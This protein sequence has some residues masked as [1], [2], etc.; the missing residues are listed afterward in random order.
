M[1][2]L[3]KTKKALMIA[4]KAF[5]NALPFFAAVFVLIGLIDVFV[6]Q[7][8]IIALMG[9]SRGIL[10]PAFA[11]FAGGILAGP[12]AAA[13]PMARV[14]LQRGAAVSAVATFIIAW[15]AVGTVSLPVEIKLLGARF[16][17][18]RWALTIVLSVILGMVI[19]WLV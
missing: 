12:P 19:G 10:A 13:Y 4:G 9:N 6:S 7:N 18:T 11:A 1:K 5:I 15:V 3:A 14:L 17:W 16:A 2:N 8:T